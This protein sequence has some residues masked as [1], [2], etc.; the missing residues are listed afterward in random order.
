MSKNKNWFIESTVEA[1]EVIINDGGSAVDF[2]IEGDTDANL[3]VTDGSADKVGIGT[4]TPSTKLEVTSDSVGELISA[5]NYNVSSIMPAE[6]MMQKSRGN[7][8]APATIIDGDE[9]GKITFKGF[10]GSNYDELAHI[11]VAS[12]SVSSD[13]SSMTF[14]S[15]KFVLDTGTLQFGSAG[16]AVTG[17]STSISTDSLDSE[18]VS[19]KAAY[20]AL[21]GGAISFSND[22]GSNTWVGT[23]ANAGKVY[24][25]STAAANG[26]F[27]QSVIQANATKCHI[28]GAVGSEVFKVTGT[29][30][31]TGAT[32]ITGAT[33]QIGALTVGVSGTGH[34]VTFYGDTADCNFLWDQS[35]DSL[36]LGANMKGVSLKAFGAGDGN[37]LHWDEANNKLNVQGG[38]ELGKTTSD[39][40][41]I[42]GIFKL[43]ADDDIFKFYANS[44][45]QAS[46][47]FQIYNENDINSF[48]IED[49]GETN[50]Q[51]YLKFNAPKFDS[52]RI[53]SLG[54][55][56]SGATSA[57]NFDIDSAG[58]KTF[59]LVQGATARIVIGTGGEATLTLPQ[60]NSISSTHVQFKTPKLMVQDVS[61]SAT[62]GKIEVAEVTTSSGNLTIDSAG[63]TVTVDDNLT[64]TGDL[65]VSGSIDSSGT[66]SDAFAVASS[67][68]NLK[69]K[70]VNITDSSL[71][72]AVGKFIHPTDS[73]GNVGTA[74]I[75]AQYIHSDNDMIISTKDSA[76]DIILAAGY[77]H[78][79]GDVKIGTSTSKQSNLICY[80]DATISGDL[81]VT[82]DITG[83]FA[84]TGT[85]SASFHLDSAGSGPKLVIGSD[86]LVQTTTTDGS[87]LNAI[88]ATGILLDNVA[89]A[90]SILTLQSYNQEIQLTPGSNAAG[91]RYVG[92]T[93]SINVAQ[94]GA[95]TYNYISGAGTKIGAASNSA[96]AGTGDMS[97]GDV[98]IMTNNGQMQF[99]A[100]AD[101]INVTG[102][103]LVFGAE[104]LAAAGSSDNKEVK[105]YGNS[106][107]AYMQWQQSSNKLLTVGTAV[108]T[109]NFQ[110]H[111]GKAVFGRSG[112][113]SLDVEFNGAAGTIASYDAGDSF[114]KM[115]QGFR[116]VP[117]VKAA[118]VTLT[119]QE[120]GRAIAIK[121]KTA[122]AVYTLP[123][124]ADG[125]NYKFMVV[126][127]DGAYD[128]E[129]KSPSATNF[130]FGGVTHLDTD[131][132]TIATVVSDN[133][134][135]DFLTLTLVEAGTM[136]EMYCDGTNWFVTGHVASATA[137]AFGDASGL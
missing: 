102:S 29:V 53:G 19:A 54:I 33:T 133:D 63:G 107:S 116:K 96:F 26:T 57:I 89:G 98:E 114:F 58:S 136:V 49:T 88:H 67:G 99:D 132:E 11:T 8:I 17:I 40:L 83:S 134:S 68:L 115:S 137:P 76:D 18:L 119:S 24:Y 103:D 122:D 106:T 60:L 66:T 92:I 36:L 52:I 55:G 100:S 81:A 14:H 41:L 42:K 82:G 120:S 31:I 64:V 86:N 25:L 121:N 9:L 131:N 20:D 13:T 78:D 32:S 50:I 7:K 104:S 113:D 73:T 4:N 51:S 74:G 59:S 108:G 97:T 84:A 101:I 38:I 85:S 93:G 129:I 117:E 118:T 124:V 45:S 56:V 91:E 43:K 69:L 12:T 126:E 23:D 35:A 123:A 87:T 75:A 5:V 16:Q 112:V 34:D 94:G 21:T 77:N 109:T 110:V 27:S 80:G 61:G 37:Y 30:G 65:T 47:I 79:S 22:S 62:A 127:K 130:F 90:S 10:D 72:I 44:T 3:L 6:I 111:T 46:D 15:D 125:L 105:F 48:W 1:G 128:V 39:E 71:P 95:T 28:G 135:N 2:R 70:A